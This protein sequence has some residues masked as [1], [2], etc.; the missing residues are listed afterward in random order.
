MVISDGFQ[1]PI[2][3]M[4]SE[5]YNTSIVSLW[6]CEFIR[7]TGDVPDVFICDMSKVLLNAAAREFANCSGIA[8]YADILIKMHSE[9]VPK[10]PPCCIRYDKNHFFKHV[11]SCE[12]LRN[13][14]KLQKEFYMHSVSLL[15]QSKSLAQA[16]FILVSVL[17]VAKCEFE[18]K[19]CLL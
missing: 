13:A 9:S 2:I 14:S 17:A 15:M 5:V 16:E 1:I 6:F 10:I 19:K 18:G 7:L 12:A 11:A 8:E 3:S 4:L